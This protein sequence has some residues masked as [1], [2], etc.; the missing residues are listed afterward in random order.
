[1]SKKDSSSSFF[2]P[3]MWQQYSMPLGKLPKTGLQNFRV[4][5]HG[6]RICQ[7][8]CSVK[9]VTPK[10][11]RT[12]TRGHGLRDGEIFESLYTHIP[13]WGQTR[14]HGAFFSGLSCCKQ[15]LVLQSLSAPLFLHFCAFCWSFCCFK[16][17]PGLALR[18]RVTFLRARKLPCALSR[19]HTW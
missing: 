14:R 12:A 8:A 19:K 17:P 9:S 4:D 10:S 18:C 6:L 5:P 2:L 15:G 11:V 13:C 7:A 1:M 3:N 16:R